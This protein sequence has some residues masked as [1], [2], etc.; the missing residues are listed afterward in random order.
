MTVSSRSDGH[1]RLRI[2][3]LLVSMVLVSSAM[4]QDGNEVTRL[5]EE[6]RQAFVGAEQSNAGARQKAVLYQV[7]RARLKLLEKFAG[8]GTSGPGEFREGARTELTR[9]ADEGLSHD[10]VSAMLLQASVADLAGTQAGAD[11]VEV[12]V[13]LHQ[14]ASEQRSP[15]YRA[16]AFVEIAHAYARAGLQD[17]ALRYATLALDTAEAVFETGTRTG[18]LNAVSRVASGLGTPGTALANRAVGFMPT[19]RSRAYARQAMAREQLKGTTMEKVPEAKLKVEAKKRMATGDLAGGLSLALALPDGKEREDILSASFEAAIERH[20]REVALAA[21]E[22]FFDSSRQETALTAIVKYDAERGT[23]LRSAELVNSMEDG[24]ARASLQLVVATELKKTGY[25]GMAERLSSG[26]SRNPNIEGMGELSVENRRVADGAAHERAGELST[27]SEVKNLIE[28][29]K[30]APIPDALLLASLGKVSRDDDKAEVAFALA[31]LPDAGAHAANLVRSIG[32]DLSRARAFRRLAQ[33]RADYLMKPLS[34]EPGES[35]DSVPAAASAS[36]DDAQELQTRRGLALIKVDAGHSANAR[37]PIPGKFATSAE[38][39][40]T[41]PWPGGAVVGS[42]FASH[43]PYIAKFLDDTEGGVTR[44][45][46]AVRYQ[47]LPSP[48]IIVVQRGTA[49][50][51]MVA[52]QLQGTDARDLIVYEGD[53]VVV[54][55]PV[56]VAPGATLLLSRLD[57]PLYRLSANAGAFIANAGEVDIVDAE[58][59][60]YDEKAKQP[61]WSDNDRSALFRPFLLTW[62]DG[63]MNVASSLLTALGYD[64]AK[65]FGLTYSSGP[66]R[67]AELRDQARPTGTVV[68]SVFRN[69]YIGLHS[70]EAER[71]QV[72]GNEYRDSIAYAVDAHDG[73]R[74]SIIA[75]NTVYGTMVRHGIAVSR[76][77]D[78]NVIVGNLSFDN[79]GSGFVLDRN[80]TNNVLYANSSFQNA[81]DGVAVFE[82]SC[83]VLTNN[84]LAGNKRDG[85]KVRNSFDVG[86]YGNRI[87]ANG[88]SGVSAYI[89]NIPISKRAD[90]HSD[91]SGHYAPVTAL[92][93]R[94]NSFSANGVG[95]NAQGVS[96]LSMFSNRFVKQSRRL[97]GG[98]IRGLEGPVL[99]LASQTDVLIASTCR[100]AKPV[101]SCRLRDRGYFEGD[102][103]RQIFN[104]QA[105]SDCTDINGSVQHRAFSSSSQGT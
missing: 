80:S 81:Q 45:E 52:R 26:A 89:A 32:D 16:A 54:R 4:A 13:T 74:G 36:K 21:A 35:V 49:T 69:L 46:Q 22:S 76:D 73:S 25:D 1:R 93:L 10:M 105:G 24:P 27:L 2:A 23:P 100:P 59:V 96:G 44:L 95:V 11:R 41:V 28:Q 7:A 8:Q 12:G 15:A 14:I 55:A 90:G 5:A 37:L 62:G 20:D 63:R 104:S 67:V 50:L 60:G 84:H 82:S 48:R 97:L 72:V 85:L 6:A 30:R 56:F 88:N 101:L 19:A 79:A 61:S 43:N 94:N 29:K 64:N 38:I 86:A 9:L 47:G 71:V 83:N 78:D 53:A 57:A 99:R 65:S 40:S 42:T 58:I 33:I 17:R 98:D 92:S 68:D 51:G 3:S 103:D 91:G 102:A 18:V 34:D 66:D 75:F 87:E 77:A 31:A 39:R 70:Y